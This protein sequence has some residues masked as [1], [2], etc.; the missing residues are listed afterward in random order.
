MYVRLQKL[1]ALIKNGDVDLAL[2]EKKKVAQMI[3]TENYRKLER[4][5]S[6]AQ[7][8]KDALEKKYAAASDKF[9]AIAQQ[10]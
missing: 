6:Y 4:Q 5:I 2:T 10:R 9:R 1:K 8:R 3:P 7:G